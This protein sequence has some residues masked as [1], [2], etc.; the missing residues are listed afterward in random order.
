MRTRL[1]FQPSLDWMPTRIAPSAGLLSAAVAPASA[2]KFA[3][4][5]NVG[6]HP[7]DS[8]DPGDTLSGNGG[9]EIIIQPVA[10]PTTPI[11]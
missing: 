9:N 10:P 6:I 8:T 3:P 4:A 2:A 7:A 11:C 5:I 1:R